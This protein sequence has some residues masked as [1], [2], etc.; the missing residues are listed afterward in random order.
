[1]HQKYKNLIWM[2]AENPL[3][4]IWMMIKSLRSSSVCKSMLEVKYRDNPTKE[5]IL[6]SKAHGV[7]FLI[8]NAC[9]YFEVATA[10]N[11]TQRLLN[12]Y[13]GT[14]SF[15]EA[16]ILANSNDF[17]S[18]DDIEHITKQGHGLYSISNEIKKVG[19][20]G[21]GILGKGRGLFPTWL[22]SR[23][24]TIDDLPSKRASTLEAPYTYSFMSLL[25]SIPELEQLIQGVEHDY[26]A[27]F[28]RPVYIMESKVNPTFNLD[29][30]KEGSYIAL[31]DYSETTSIED[32]K[33][34]NGSL[35]RF[36]PYD[37]KDKV[38]AYKVLIKHLPG[39][40]WWEKVN[41]HKSAFCDNTI[42][43]PLLKDIDDWEV[44]AV[45][46]L[47]CVSILVRYNPSI[48]R[49]IQH[50]EWDGY[51]AIFDQFAMVVERVIPNIFYERI[52]G[53]KLNIKMPG[54]LG[55]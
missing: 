31:Y 23:G 6:T 19:D 9:D 39:E 2:T 16:E 42:L 35:D 55:V 49:K 7:S 1:M 26:H 33:A 10:N 25:S 5:D 3:Q 28:F 17:K 30:P 14:L 20:I 41:T 11:S 29:V 36:E 24:K 43:K 4:Q 51:S 44:Y 21:V 37:N 38:R 48:W 8:Q 45:M 22:Y 46:I 12:L 40:Y 54:S 47:Y 18:L 52:T 50:G 32:A 15:M 34:L 27:G 13:Y 53:N